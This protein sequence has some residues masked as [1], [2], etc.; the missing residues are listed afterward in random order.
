[1]SIETKEQEYLPVIVSEYNLILKKKSKLPRSKRDKMQAIA[2]TL[3]KK[4]KL[5]KTESGKVEI[6]IRV[7]M[8]VIRID[9]SHN[10]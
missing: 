2:E 5:V 7:E 4:G 6:Y 10:A 3:I 8:P 1:M 9:V